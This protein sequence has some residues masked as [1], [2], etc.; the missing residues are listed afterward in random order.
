MK[1]VIGLGNPGRKYK[2]TRH[3]IGFDVIGFLAQRHNI[4]R[5]K[6]KFNAEIAEAIINN[7]KTV[8]LCPLTF[9]N[10]SGQSV[11][12]AVDFYKLELTDLIVVCDDLALNVARLRLRPGGSAGGQ[13]GLVDIIEKLGSL[14]F[15]RLRVGIGQPPN[16]WD[17]ADYVLGRYAKE[18]KPAIEEAMVRSADAIEHWISAGIE[19]AMNKFNPDTNKK[20]KQPNEKNG[21]LKSA[22]QPIENPPIQKIEP[23]ENQ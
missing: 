22:S 20:P 14:D 2:G 16:G 8:L 17:S 6:S 13:K 12:A 1:L 21:K 3:N 7:E 10:L 15:A 18:E 23:E 19:S 5:P 4:G 11:R 9:M